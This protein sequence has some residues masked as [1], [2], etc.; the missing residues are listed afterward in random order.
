MS[1]VANAS[2]PI[3][4]NHIAINDPCDNIILKSGDEIPAKVIEIAADIIKYKRCDYIDGPIISM[5]KSDI[6]MIRYSN[7]S[8]EIFSSDIKKPFS[9][10][11]GESGD[12]FWAGTSIFSL[13]VAIIGMVVAGALPLGILAVIT[14]I[15]ALREENKLVPIAVIGIMLGLIDIILILSV[16]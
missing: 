15:I 16:L 10:I 3:V 11:E 14:G 9:T 7:G 4:E 6:L 8:K 13:M 12:G 2:F 5:P 1:T